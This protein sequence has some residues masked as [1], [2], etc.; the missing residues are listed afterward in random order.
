MNRYN[1]GNRAGYFRAKCNLDPLELEYWRDFRTCDS[2]HQALTFAQIKNQKKD[3]EKIVENF[4]ALA[5]ISSLK[6]MAVA[7]L[8]IEF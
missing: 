2:H 5:R 1:T 4:G 6:E 3:L 7:G 8:K